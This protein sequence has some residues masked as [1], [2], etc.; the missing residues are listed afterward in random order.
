MIHT[1]DWKHNLS[2]KRPDQSCQ[3]AVNPRLLKPIKASKYATTFQ[4]FQQTGSFNGIDT[5]SATSYGKFNFGSKLSMEAEARSI[6]NRHDLNAHLSKLRQDGVIS[7]FVEA[8][9]RDF[10]KKHSSTID[11]NKYIKDTT[12]VSLENSTILQEEISNNRIQASLDRQPGNRPVT[13]YLKKY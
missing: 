10:S 13:F 2:V 1:Y 8:G 4:L 6:S 3:D 7:E 9:N 12:F 5:C 11:Y